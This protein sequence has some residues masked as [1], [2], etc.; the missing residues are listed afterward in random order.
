MYTQSPLLFEAPLAHEVGVYTGY[1]NCRECRSNSAQAFAPGWAESDW[2]AG[3]GP[4]LQKEP[5]AVPLGN[6]VPFATPPQIGYWPIKGVSKKGR[7]VSYKVSDGSIEGRSGRMFL[8]NR[9]GRGDKAGVP[10]WHVGVDLFAN[11]GDVVVACEDGTILEF[12]PFY[13]A[14]S[15]QMTYRL[16][17]EHSTAVVNYGEVTKDSLT[18]NQLRVGMRVRAGQ[19]VA[20]VSDTSMLHFETYIRGTTRNYRWWK[21]GER[22]QQLLNPTRYL[23]FLQEHGLPQQA[24]GSRPA[25]SPSRQRS[26][27][28]YQ[29]P[30]PGLQLPSSPATAPALIRSENQ[31]PGTTLYVDIRLGQEGRARPMTGIFIPE[32]YRLQAKVDILLYLPGFKAGRNQPDPGWSIDW[33]WRN[34]VTLREN[35]NNSHKSLVLAAPTLG[36]NSQ[37]GWLIAPGG[38]DRYLNSVMAAL[39]AYGPYQGKHATVGNII[40]ACHS[41]GG[42]PMGILAQSNQQ[43]SPLLR[44]CWGFDCM[45]NGGDASRWGNW[46]R[47]NPNA[48]LYN[49]YR[50]NSG[51]AKQSEMLQRLNL[52]NV[53]VVALKPEQVSHY[54]V[55]RENLMKRLTGTK[56]LHNTTGK[57]NFW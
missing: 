24:S 26:G 29:N 7:L 9:E 14:K 2:E 32:G 40:L 41:G 4:N 16:L 35:F 8:G 39:S 21:N 28:R 49:Y 46:A 38:L 51:T 13:P 55:V 52:S 23:L 44:E 45:Y 30:A 42:T 48:K 19:P 20:F 27:H 47:Q 12:A 11:T 10:R 37:A 5:L 15:G 36:K 53:S 34:L 3:V 6:P 25:P 22:P 31:P 17:I 33:Y 54:G 18:R 43:Y 56:S 50:L 57:S 1:C